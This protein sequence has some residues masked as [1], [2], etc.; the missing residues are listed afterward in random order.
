MTVL[1]ALGSLLWNA[2][3]NERDGVDDQAL[4]EARQR[5]ASAQQDEERRH[6]QLADETARREILAREEKAA[7]MAAGAQTPPDETEPVLGPNGL[8]D[9]G[10]PFDPHNLVLTG[11]RVYDNKT[12]R[13]AAHRL[14]D[15]GDYPAA[16]AMARKVL[17]EEPD[18]A[19]AK[20]LMVRAACAMGDADLARE[21]HAQLSPGD[22]PRAG[23]PCREAGIEF[24]EPDQSDA[25]AI[26]PGTT[27]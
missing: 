24:S 26:G 22:K 3:S 8:P 20:L 10:P 19:R 25:P 15:D 17:A 21:F 2:R 18:D 1:V 11:D 13:S 27:E 7:R 5:H 12:R 14:Y 6:R 9:R 4:E 16:V 23:L